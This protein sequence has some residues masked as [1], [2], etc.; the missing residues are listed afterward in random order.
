[1]FISS[2]VYHCLQAVL[3]KLI[4]QKHNVFISG[5]AT[6]IGAVV[7]TIYVVASL[8]QPVGGHLAD[9][10]S[11]KPIYIIGFLVQIPLF[12]SL[13]VLT[14]IPMICAIVIMLMFLFAVLP[15]ENLML[16]H[17]SPEKHHRLVYGIK[18]VLVF[19]AAPIAVQLVSWVVGWAA[20][21]GGC[22]DYLAGLALLITCAAF[23]LL[24]THLGRFKQ[25]T[26]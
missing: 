13:T 23:F 18:C 21:V 19:G 26:D 22:F 1:M 12:L 9:R 5:T 4:E 8:M 25:S 17:Y 16:A 3:P 6:Q 2:I 11:L 24:H 7:A 20:N 14:G 15:A 10:F